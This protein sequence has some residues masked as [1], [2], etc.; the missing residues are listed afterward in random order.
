MQGTTR[1]KHP[2]RAP[3]N[4]QP[5]NSCTVNSIR[6][7]ISSCN[8]LYRKDDDIELSDLSV[9]VVCA[10]GVIMAVASIL[11]VIGFTYRRIQADRERRQRRQRANQNRPLVFHFH[12]L[13]FVVSA[14]PRT[15]SLQ[16]K[17]K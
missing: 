3:N 13:V 5:P 4:M 7:A 17:S 11:M 10:F 1:D 15:A 12:S 2:S 9:L 16:S 14:K 6:D 8:S